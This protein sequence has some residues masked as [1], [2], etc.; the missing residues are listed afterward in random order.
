MSFW[1][2]FFFPEF[3]CG[4]FPYPRDPVVG[5]CLHQDARSY[6]RTDIRGKWLPVDYLSCVTDS[7]ILNDLRFPRP[8]L[9]S[10][11][12][13]PDSSLPPRGP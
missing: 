7:T 4:W 2:R 10:T 6:E 5:D 12:Y 9:V 1:I 3:P 13:F 11:H 8:A